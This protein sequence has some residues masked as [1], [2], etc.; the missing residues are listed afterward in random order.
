LSPAP[1]AYFSSS[2]AFSKG[3]GSETIKVSMKEEDWATL[4]QFVFDNGYNDET[5][6]PILASLRE[7]TGINEPEV[8]TLTT[9]TLTPNSADKDDDIPF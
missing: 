6:A 4:I 1:Y 7:Q 8:V 2:Q 9:F 5:I 3:G